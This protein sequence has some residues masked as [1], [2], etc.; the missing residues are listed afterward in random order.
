VSK[1][2]LY[3]AMLPLTQSRIFLFAI[4]LDNLFASGSFAL[5]LQFV[6]FWLSEHKF[7]G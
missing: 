6:A 2:D 1:A 7:S 4:M 3:A 5:F